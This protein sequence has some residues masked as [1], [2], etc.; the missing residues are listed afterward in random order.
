MICW[1]ALVYLLNSLDVLLIL[2][3]LLIRYNY[4]WDPSI[5]KTT[6][7]AI[8]HAVLIIS[9]AHHPWRDLEVGWMWWCLGPRCSGGLGSAGL[10][11]VIPNVF[12]NLNN[13]MISRHGCDREDTTTGQKDKLH[14]EK[15]KCHCQTTDSR[16]RKTENA[17]K[18]RG[19][20]ICQERQE[21]VAHWQFNPC[22]NFVGIPDLS[23]TTG[24]ETNAEPTCPT[25]TVIS[26]LDHGVSAV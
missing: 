12:S 7:N 10:D 22:C 5:Y 13:S 1:Q 6:Q 8:I 21:S 9:G 23:K 20:T 16:L 25:I 24:A 19:N 14:Q 15:L 26:K 18:L 17:K 2:L 3:I 4:K 11:L